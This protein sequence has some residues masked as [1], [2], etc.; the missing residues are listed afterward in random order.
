MLVIDDERTLRTTLAGLL[1]DRYEVVLAESGAAAFEIFGRD[2][3]FDAIL[4]DLMMPEI[5]GMQVHAWVQR[6]APAMLPRMVFMTGGAFTRNAS[7]FLEHVQNRHIEKPFEVNDLVD[8]LDR[9]IRKAAA[10]RA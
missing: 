4:C 7:E 8:V 2:R 5:S 10:A 3:D 6:E 1:A 9:T